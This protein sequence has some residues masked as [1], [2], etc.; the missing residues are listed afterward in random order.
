MGQQTHTPPARYHQKPPNIVDMQ[1]GM[2]SRPAP[3]KYHHSHKAFA[4]SSTPAAWKGVADLCLLNA[5][6]QSH[7][8]LL[9]KAHTHLQPGMGQQIWLVGERPNR[10]WLQNAQWIGGSA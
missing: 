2:R 7:K 3:S 9:T 10:G 4:D 8:T 6:N 5:A 1:P